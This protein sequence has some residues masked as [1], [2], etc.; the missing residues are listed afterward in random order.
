[1]E[2]SGNSMLLEQILTILCRED[3]H[4]HED[5]IQ[6]SLAR[7]MKR[8]EFFSNAMK[9][10]LQHMTFVQIKSKWINVYSVDILQMHKVICFKN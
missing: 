2:M 7:F 6:T 10:L 4:V 3:R 1:M 8:S 5:A 9:S